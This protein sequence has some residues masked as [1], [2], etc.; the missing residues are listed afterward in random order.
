MQE[1]R[2]PKSVRRVYVVGDDQAVCVYK[3]KRKK[4][5]ESKLIRPLGKMIRRMSLAQRDSSTEYLRRFDR[6]R[7]KKRNGWIRDH[8]KNQSK[9][10]RKGFKQ[11]KK[12][13][14]R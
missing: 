10:M 3:K 1:I 11:L 8:S 12:I 13:A 4:K 5:K 9:A 7:A 2:L 14:K 6:S